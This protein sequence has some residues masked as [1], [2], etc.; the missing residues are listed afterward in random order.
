[1]TCEIE[2]NKDNSHMLEWLKKRGEREPGSNP[3]RRSLFFS[4]LTTYERNVYE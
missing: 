3:V 1:M 2:A 4:V